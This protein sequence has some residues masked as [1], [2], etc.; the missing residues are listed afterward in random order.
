M[1]EYFQS[2]FTKEVIGNLKQLKTRV[3]GERCPQSFDFI[4]FSEE[5]VYHELCKI[6]V[7][8][9]SGPDGLHGRLLKEASP[10]IAKSLAKLFAKSLE[11]GCLPKD[12]RIAN[13]TPIHKK[14]SHHQPGH[15]RP[16]SK[17]YLISS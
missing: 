10:F 3:S 11:T 2:I 17:S 5:E 12:W 8:K 14:G 9:A 4:S 16:V 1:N 7:K 13:I 6:D 15:Y